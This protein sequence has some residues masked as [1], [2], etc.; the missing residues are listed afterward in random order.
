M[1]FT[2]VVAEQALPTRKTRKKV[3]GKTA[4]PLFHL[5]PVKAGPL[6]NSLA[7]YFCP[8][9]EWTTGRSSYIDSAE[10]KQEVLPNFFRLLKLCHPSSNW[11]NQAERR[12]QRHTKC[13]K[14]L[15]RFLDLLLPML[16]WKMLVGEYGRRSA[17]RSSQTNR[18]VTT[19]PA[20]RDTTTTTTA[21]L[22]V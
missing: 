1:W 21:A 17:T 18:V 13:G 12:H 9:S 10:K 14:K 4:L 8:A 7:L 16:Y 2:N 22:L 3:R 20:N 6:S 15:N 11:P 5:S 19:W